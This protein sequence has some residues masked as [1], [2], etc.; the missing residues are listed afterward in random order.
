MLNRTTKIL[1]ATAVLLLPTAL[2]AH[3]KMKGEE[4]KEH[5]KMTSAPLDKAIALLD[6]ASTSRDAA[7]KDQALAQART[8][9]KEVK[10]HMSHC[11]MMDGMDMKGMDHGKMGGMMMADPVSGAQVDP[12]T[13]VKSV[14]AGK[15]YYF[16]S[17]EN[18]A[19]FDKNP[20]TYLKKG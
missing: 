5:C 17:A 6:Q 9:L 10:E 12:K 3:E 13:A 15:A 1:A 11:M 4:A 14:Y 7:Q 8:Q 18:K 20:E 19:K 2:F 16:A